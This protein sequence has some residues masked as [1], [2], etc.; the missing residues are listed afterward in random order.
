MLFSKPKKLPVAI[1][2]IENTIIT[3]GKMNKE[4]LNP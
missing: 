3:I 4:I 2:P 1:E